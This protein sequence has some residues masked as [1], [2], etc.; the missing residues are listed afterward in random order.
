MDKKTIAILGATGSI[1]TQCLDILRQY[2]N[3]FHLQLISANQRVDAL[4]RIANEFHV[5][6]VGF[7][8]DSVSIPTG[9]ERETVIGR[10]NIIEFFRK[11][12]IHTVVFGSSGI[13][14]YDILLHIYSYVE[15][16][17]IASKEIIVLAGSTGLLDTIQN[18]TQL[19]PVD[20]EHAAIYQLM[21]RCPRDQIRKVYLTASGGPFYSQ[22]SD[23]S[24]IKWDQITPQMALKHPTWKM[25]KKVT[26]DSASMANKG[27]ELFEASALFS[28]PTSQLEV[29][30]HPQSIVHAMIESIDG[31][32]YSQSAWPDMRLPIAFALFHPHR[33]AIDIGK[34]EPFFSQSPPLTFHAVEVGRIP[35]LASAYRALQ[36]N[37]L[38]PIVYLAADEVAV[39]AFLQSKISFPQIGRLLQGALDRYAYEPIDVLHP[40]EQFKK[41]QEKIR[42]ELIPD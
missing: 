38:S 17:C 13:E 34:P 23:L 36:E 10:N 15:R 21:E 6:Y 12:S 4:L 2:P 40:V 8:N 11:H 30:I 14:D 33:K 39:D 9:I 25:G 20:S 28:L 29:V 22:S 41:L 5:P 18:T 19:L 37:A 24:T 27:I 35:T 26:I 3:H 7:H 16:I 32:I 42:R 1:G 31:V